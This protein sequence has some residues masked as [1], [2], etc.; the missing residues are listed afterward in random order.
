MLWIALGLIALILILRHFSP[1]IYRVDT[2]PD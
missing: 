1:K 2:G